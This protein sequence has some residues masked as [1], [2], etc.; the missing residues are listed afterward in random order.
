MFFMSFCLKR[1][2]GEYVLYVFLSKKR[3]NENM[4]F[5]SF[6][7][8]KKSMSFCLQQS[9]LSICRDSVVILTLTLERLS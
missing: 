3:N 5:M 8:K 2:E 7:L 4:F 9:S 6:C 1:T